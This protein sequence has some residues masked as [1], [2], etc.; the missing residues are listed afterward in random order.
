MG[1]IY[2]LGKTG[3]GKSTL[4]E[5][6]ATSDIE[7]GNG[8]AVLDPHGDVAQNLIKRMPADRAADLIYLNPKDAAQALGFNPLHNVPSK[9]H[10]LVASGLVGTFKKVW[11]DSWG[12]RMEHILRYAILTL[13]HVP[14]STLL[15]VQPLL[16]DPVKQQHAL[17][18]V[19]DKHIRDFWEHEFGRYTK[20]FKQEAVAPV[21]NKLGLLTASPA[22][23]AILGKRVSSFRMLDVMNNRKILICNLSKGQL[24]EDVSSL[25]GAILLT[26]IQNAALYRASVLQVERVPFFVYIDEMHSF[27]TLSFAS[28]LAEGRKYAL[29]LFMAHQYLDQLDERIRSAI[30]GNVGTLITFRVGA[31]DAELLSKEFHPV[32]SEED[33]VHLPRYSM[34]L[35][36]MIDGAT[37]VPFSACSLL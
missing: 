31:A 21:L 16:T 17:S 35:K 7:R 14:G 2:V 1:H 23:R 6:M 27:I 15:D 3:T 34:C 9:F 4:L 13:L 20:S 28:I 22:L 25:L 8:L 30:F 18:Y 11:V 37:S 24:G 12:P 32:F 26:S 19:T 5:N 10:S 33:L 36:L 29:S